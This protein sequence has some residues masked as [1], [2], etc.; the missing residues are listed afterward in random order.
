MPM[1]PAK[2]VPLGVVV[3]AGSIGRRHA[4]ALAR[5]QSSPGSR[6]EAV[7]LSVHASEDPIDDRKW[8]A[9]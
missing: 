6:G 9:S 4:L 3:G 7:R 8:A 1:T 2:S 5:R